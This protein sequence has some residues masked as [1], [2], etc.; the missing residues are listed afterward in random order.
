MTLFIEQEGVQRV[1]ER[2]SG[3]VERDRGDRWHPLFPCRQF[4][5]EETEELVRLDSVGSWGHVACDEAANKLLENGMDHRSNLECAEPSIAIVERRFMRPDAEAITEKESSRACA[6]GLEAV[7]RG[8]AALRR[9]GVKQGA[10][11]GH[12]AVVWGEGIALALL[13]GP[14]AVGQMVAVGTHGGRS[15][16]LRRIRTDDGESGLRLIESQ[17]FIL[18]HK[19]FRN[20]CSRDEVLGLHGRLVVNSSEKGEQHW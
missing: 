1:G 15:H 9:T 5:I 14:Y 12:V 11:R 7:R 10:C 2:V 4:D 8:F 18:R 17:R 13:L 3:A 19:S 6:E 16:F 20:A